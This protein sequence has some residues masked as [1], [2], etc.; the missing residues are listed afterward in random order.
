VTRT[1]SRSRL[2]ELGAASSCRSITN[3]LTYFDCFVLDL[4]VCAGGGT[5][6][7]AHAKQMLFY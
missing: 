3:L 1:D 6:G 7:L 2:E 5:Q 4:F